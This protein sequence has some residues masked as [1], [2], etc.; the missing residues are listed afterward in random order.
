MVTIR[1]SRMHRDRSGK[2]L[3]LTDRDREIFRA[4]GGYRFLR[5][6]YLH[7]FAGGASET[8]FKERLG[9]LFHEGYLDRPT[10]QW[11]LAE[12]RHAPAVHELGAGARAIIA[13]DDFSERTW[14]GGKSPRQFE[15][16]LMICEVLAS[17]ELATQQR[18]DVRF[19]P[20]GEIKCRRPGGVCTDAPSLGSAV[21][22]DALFG[23]E[24]QRGDRKLYRFFAVEAD[25]GTMPIIRG[26]TRQTSLIGKVAAY[27]DGFARQWY[28]TELGIPNL[29]LLIVTISQRRADHLCQ[30]VAAQADAGI[31]VLVK[32]V[33]GGAALRRP[34]PDLLDA[35]WERPGH[36][37]L[38]IADPA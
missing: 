25:R 4:L 15:H 24:Y 12:G 8:R 35:P 18:G 30:E 3:E 16:A 14:L 36:T 34:L 9:D 33:A 13:S 5:S 20:W 29:L 32:H 26:D 10:E 7:A 21:K 31:P 38:I 28:K 2:R 19:I 17:I 27:R 23:I 1:R 6:T 11:K 37:P 22:P